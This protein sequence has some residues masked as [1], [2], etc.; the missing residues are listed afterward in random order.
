MKPISNC[1]FCNKP[2]KST[3][4]LNNH[5][6]KNHGK[7]SCSSNELTLKRS[8]TERLLPCL[9]C[10]SYKQMRWLTTIIY[11]KTIFFLLHKTLLTQMLLKYSQIIV[12][13]HS[14]FKLPLTLLLTPLLQII[15]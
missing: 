2:Y 15:S 9:L 8:Q 10:K 5:I 6:I 14:P 7:P 1:I 4:A 12:Q 3:G 13:I 11:L